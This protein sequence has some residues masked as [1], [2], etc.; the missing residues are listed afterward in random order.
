MFCPKCR[1]EFVKDVTICGQCK[2]SL[3]DE[4]QVQAEDDVLQGSLSEVFTALN[5]LESGFVQSLL[6]AN[7]INSHVDNLH[8]TSMQSIGAGVPIKVMVAQKDKERALEIINQYYEDIKT[9][10]L[11]VDDLQGEFYESDIIDIE[12]TGNLLKLLKADDLST[13][14]RVID[15]D[16]KNCD[17]ILRNAY[18]NE[19][20]KRTTDKVLLD[21]V[22]QLLDY[23]ENKSK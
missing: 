9:M 10:P 20:I 16:M 11:P 3:I 22:D 2:I 1:A 14:K 13:A 15:R 18:A 7:Q 8:F 23:I 21:K 6:K 19:K 17:K 5:N 12:T 4:L